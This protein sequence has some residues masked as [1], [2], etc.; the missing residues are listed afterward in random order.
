MPLRCESCGYDI[1]GLPASGACP[2][3]GEAVAQSLP[4]HRTGSSWQQKRGVRAWFATNRRTL[5]HPGHQFRALRVDRAHGR[6]LLT[7]NLATAS[8]L[9]MVCMAIS[10]PGWNPVMR[11]V[12]AFAAHP[13]VGFLIL[14]GLTEL[15]RLGV[16]FFS[17]RRRWPLPKTAAL[18]ICA[19]ASVG[20]I[21]CGPLGLALSVGGRWTLGVILDGITPERAPSFL[22]VWRL[23]V[24]MWL[25]LI[26]CL[27]GMLIFETLVYIGVRRC[28]FANAPA[29]APE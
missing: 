14:A 21:L 22:N 16:L 8:F 11:G 24:P 12:L 13:V 20:W 27:A 26:G 15:E 19:H 23:Y 7:L 1:T 2:E 3:C 10:S 28:R 25:F 29:S 5:T 6:A 18:Q 4:G 17:S 9:L